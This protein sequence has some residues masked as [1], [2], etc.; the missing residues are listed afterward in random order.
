MLSLDKY[1]TKEIIAFECCRI[2]GKVVKIDGYNDLI[3]EPSA[4]NGSFIIPI[5]RFCNNYIFLDIKPDYRH[6]IKQDFLDFKL[7]SN[8]Y[9]K[10]HIIGNP[11]FGFKSTMAIKFIK[12]SCKICDYFGFI[13]PLSFNNDSMKR[14][15]PHNFHL[16][17]SNQLPINSFVYN[18][19]SY[20]VPC[21][22]QIWEKRTYDRKTPIL[23]SPIGYKFSKK[24]AFAIRRVGHNAGKIYKIDKTDKMVYN[25]NTHYFFNLNDD[26]NIIKLK[27]ITFKNNSVGAKSI[28]KQYII[29]K[30]NKMLS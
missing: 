5:K 9:R 4:G 1:Y 26:N 30:L 3:I 2:Y 27:D 22:F 19:A 25:I 17:Y 18:E 16:L 28:S 20:N 13:L 11:P 6:I 12:K 24:G 14:S 7:K 23:L 15:V 21:V 10:I 29:K 8:N